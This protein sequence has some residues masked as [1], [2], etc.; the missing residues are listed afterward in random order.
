M[1]FVV[2]K[3]TE[4]KEV[5]EIQKFCTKFEFSPYCL[6]HCSLPL[7]PDTVLSKMLNQKTQI[8]HY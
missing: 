2:E 1:L 8:C 3:I 4:I 7:I 5:T 6:F